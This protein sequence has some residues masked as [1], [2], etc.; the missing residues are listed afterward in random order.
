M[1]LLPSTVPNRP[2]PP[3]RGPA[4]FFVEHPLLYALSLAGAGS[5]ALIFARRGFRSRGRAQLAWSALAVLELGILVGM[6]R[7]RVSG[8][9]SEL[10]HS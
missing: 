10:P 7:L 1:S 6:V 9:R 8:R 5:A 4:H 3:T 2:P